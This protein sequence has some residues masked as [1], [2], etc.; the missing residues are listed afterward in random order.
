MLGGVQRV[1]GKKVR[2][3]SIDFNAL[4]GFSTGFGLFEKKEKMKGCKERD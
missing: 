3:F 4:A 2:S 1:P